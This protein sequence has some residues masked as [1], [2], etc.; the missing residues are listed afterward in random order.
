MRSLLIFISCALIFGC[1]DDITG[2]HIEK[3]ESNEIHSKLITHKDNSN[4]ILVVVIP[5]SGGSYLPDEHLFGLVQSGYDALSI[6]YVGERGL[7]N[8]I[9]QVSLEYLKKTIALVKKRFPERKIVL[10]GISKGAEYALTFASKYNIIDGIIC[11]SPSCIVLPNHVGLKKNEPQKSSWTFNGKE[12]P[13]TELD[14]FNDEAGKITYNKYIKPV[15]DDV[16]ELAESRIKV[17]NIKCDLLLLS[18]ENDL[19][20]PA[21]RMSNLIQSKIEEGDSN[22]NVEHIS[23]KNCGHQFVWFDKKAPENAPQYQSMNLTG[24]KKHKFLF[25]GTKESTI[26]AMIDSRIKVI[27]FLKKIETI[28][29]KG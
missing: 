24:I 1:Q 13:F 27:E 20:W 29:N 2:I 7:P 4:H 15:L 11:Y 3:I 12:I 18:G 17:E 19:V 8:K 10:L 26:N 9:E 23:Y 16:E 28:Q 5:G 25:G 21:T 22:I 6:A 14:F